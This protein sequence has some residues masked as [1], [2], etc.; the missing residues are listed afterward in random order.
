MT[1][2]KAFYESRIIKFQRQLKTLK[3]A[4]NTSST[5]RLLVFVGLLIT[6]YFVWGNVQVIL[7]I[8]GI[9][10]A[11]FIVLLLRHNKLIY[12]R[13][14]LQALVKINQT[15]LEVL[16][17]NF[18]HLPDGMEYANA[19]HAFSQ[20]IDLFGRGSFFQYSNRTS[21]KSGTEHLVH[22]L[23]SNNIDSIQEKQGAIKELAALPEWRQQFGA[24]A[25]LVKI[26]V[27]AKSVV[28][29]LANYKIF[30]PKRA[31]LISTIFSILS[32]AVWALYFLDFLSGYIVFGVFLLGLAISGRY[33]KGINKLAVHTTQIQST[34][35][36]YARL[37]SL[38]ENQKF[39]AN[40]LKR[41]QN[42]VVRKENS[43]SA[44]LKKFSK[45][46]DALDQRNNILIS[47]VAN[48]FFL[49]DLYICKSI[50]DWILENRKEVPKWFETIA[51]FDAYSSLGNY[52]FNH[53]EYVYPTLVN[54][55]KTMDCKGAAHP[56]LNPEIAI[57]NDF[58]ISKDEFFVITGANMAGKSTF[59]RTVG[60]QIVMANVGL[61]LCA[62][63][64]NYNPAK[65]I[66]SM[67]TTDS[68]T[69]DESYFFS[70]LKRLKVIIDTIEKEPHFIILDEILKGT[71][72]TDKAVGSK[73]F[74]ERLVRLKA[75]GIIATHDLSLCSLADSLNEVKN[76]Y[77]DAQIKNGEL[78]FDYTF[79]EGVCQNMNA[80]FLLTRMGIV[81]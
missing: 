6:L 30:V 79:K 19:D 62:K 37:I 5:L 36:Q 61:P 77:F 17:R 8:I 54:N 74:I 80:S 2:P 31:K 78:Y 11:L 4:V 60:L 42:K 14:L 27:S 46:L 67:R 41:E 48:S 69:D 71:N 15:E 18:H 1:A 39:N 21:L 3:T 9:T 73:K 68:L 64:V 34:F 59:L 44:L 56:L 66:T 52:A 25:T 32:I 13:D 28:D 38:L 70:E 72:S 65:L 20:D 10:S 40:Y 75:S 12:E 57:A 7:G 22:D 45:L 50:E 29:W 23:L 63:D 16:N 24:E 58:E 35:R 53:D 49:R 81:D 26:E 55:N 51:F 76:Y 33:L 43:S 47:I